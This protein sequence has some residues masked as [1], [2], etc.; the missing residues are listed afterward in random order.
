MVILLPPARK[1]GQSLIEVVAAMAIAVLIITGLVFTA[2]EAIKNAQFSKN[3]ALA[4]K[5]AEEGMDWVR[6][7]RDR[8]TVWADFF[9]HVPSTVNTSNTFCLNSLSWTSGSCG[10]SYT[11]GNLFK[12]EAILTNRAADKVEVQITVAWI[13][14]SGSHQSQLT[15]FLSN[16]VTR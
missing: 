11:L 10:A 6:S 16:W 5:Y 3:Q 12:R 7:Q 13:D 15:S 2:G 14:S 9:A 1:N 8:A 4:T